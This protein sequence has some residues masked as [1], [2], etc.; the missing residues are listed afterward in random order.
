M[1]HNHHNLATAVVVD[2]A[3]RAASAEISALTSSSKSNDSVS[4]GSRGSETRL[5]SLEVKS[6]TNNMG[7]SHRGTGD[8]VGSSVGAD[9]RRQD[10]KAGSEDVDGAAEVGKV[11]AGVVAADGADGE[12]GRGRGGGGAGCVD[13]FDEGT[14]LGVADTVAGCDHGEDTLLGGGVDEGVEGGGNGVLRAKRHVDHSLAGTTLVDDVVHSPFE[15]LH[16]GGG[17]TGLWRC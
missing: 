15:A 3:V 5:Q 17:G 13:G 2:N 1:C 7:A 14:S 9:P 4:S 8:S 12:G 10:V 11:G 16:D 6:K